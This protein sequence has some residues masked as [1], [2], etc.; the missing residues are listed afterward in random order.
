MSTERFLKQRGVNVALDGHYTLPNWYDPEGKLRTFSC[1]TNRVSP[2][3]MI[4]DVP[5]VGKVGDYLTSY[6]R[7][8]GKLDGRISDTKPGCFLLELDVTYATRERIAN[9][10]TWLEE[11]QKDPEIIDL[12]KNPRVIPAKSHTTLTLADGGVHECFVIDM[13]VTGAAVSA[14]VELEV[15]TPLAIGACVG[16]V[17]RAS[18]SGVAVRFVEKQN[19]YEL[20][21]LVI[22]PLRLLNRGLRA[23]WE[24]VEDEPAAATG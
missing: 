10:L 3:R 18:A 22:R 16:R 12:R 2:Y 15:G 23:D 14:Q 17:V 4:V 6:F 21:R 8:F 19:Q 11:K 24:D 1:R 13:S 7:D 20:E 5:M 9:K